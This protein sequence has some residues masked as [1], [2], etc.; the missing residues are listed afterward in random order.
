MRP[1]RPRRLLA[2][3][4][5]KRAERNPVATR[6]QPSSVQWAIS[7]PAWDSP[8]V[9]VRQA[10]RRAARPKPARAAAARPRRVARARRGALKA[11]FAAVA[12]IASVRAHE[13]YLQSDDL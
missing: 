2:K 11:S 1:P 13:A 8:T 5:L 3:A 4:A 9:A 10:A 12:C 7:A 6:I